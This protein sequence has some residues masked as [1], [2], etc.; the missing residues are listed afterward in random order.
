MEK[1]VDQVEE[2][3]L[4]VLPLVDQQVVLEVEEEQFRHHLE[5]LVI[6]LQQVHLKEIMVVV[7]LDLFFLVLVGVVLE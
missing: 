5:D 3:L 2:V 7:I 4:M 6:H 1:V